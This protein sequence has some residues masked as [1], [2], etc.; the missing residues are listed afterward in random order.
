VL[1]AGCATLP[2]VT[3]EA[4]YAGRFALAVDG[5]GRHETASGRFALAVSGSDVT[6]DLST[7]LGTTV[8]RVQAG[9]DGARLTVPTAG[10]LRTERGPDPEALSLKVLGWTLP[11]SGIGDW[12]EGR[13]V[14]DRPYRMEPGDNGATEL[15]QDGWTIRFDPRGPDGRI[16]RLDMSRPQ[17]GEAP[18]VS[19]RVVLDPGAGS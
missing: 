10:G 18:A 9:A 15:Q 11:V 6:L 4:S 13:P 3:G 12:I 14:K 2:P 1:A 17:Q 5:T 16:R 7:P 19:L 8:A